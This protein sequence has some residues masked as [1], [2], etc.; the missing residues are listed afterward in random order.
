MSALIKYFCKLSKLFHHSSSILVGEI[1]ELSPINRK[2]G[3]N[4]LLVATMFPNAFTFTTSY[5]LPCHCPPWDRLLRPPCYPTSPSAGCWCMPRSL[6]PAEANAFTTDHALAAPRC[7]LW[8]EVQEYTP[9]DPQCCTRGSPPRRRRLPGMLPGPL[10]SGD[11]LAEGAR[12]SVG[13]LQVLH[14]ARH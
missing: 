14:A 9:C 2:G 5:V 8:L 4:Y 6:D 11:R 7:M 12:V 3:S 13:A 1:F 10:G